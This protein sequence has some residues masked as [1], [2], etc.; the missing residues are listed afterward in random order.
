M[1]CGEDLARFRQ[2][3]DRLLDHF[4]FLADCELLAADADLS[5][6]KYLP[7]AYLDRPTLSAPLWELVTAAWAGAC[8]EQQRPEYGAML[9]TGRAGT[10]KS[11]LLCDLTCRLLDRADSGH[12]DDGHGHD[13]CC[14]AATV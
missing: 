12:G 1:V 7:A 11:A 10:G 5:G 3:L 13:W 14:C 9:I 4:D 8:A 2:P 6:S